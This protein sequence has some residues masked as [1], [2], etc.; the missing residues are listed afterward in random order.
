MTTTIGRTDTEARKAA[1]TGKAYKLWY[2]EGLH[3]FVTPTGTKSWRAKYRLNGK[4]GT[5]VLGQFPTMTTDEAR[6]GCR[7]VLKLVSRGINP[8]AERKRRRAKLQSAD[9]LTVEA[10]ALSWFKVMRKEWSAGYAPQVEARL[11]NHVF[12]KLGAMPIAGVTGKQVQD[13]LHDIADG[14]KERKALPAQAVH[15]RHHL[16]GLFDYSTA[17]EWT[18]EN[19]VRRVGAYLP[20]R[21]KRDEDDA[22]TEGEESKGEE[23]QAHVESIEEAREVLATFEAGAADPML[24]LAHRF[25]ALTATRKL[26]TVEAEWSEISEDGTTWT[27]PARRMKGRRGAK[28]IHVVPLSPAAQDVLRTARVVARSWR[29]TSDY[30]F[31]SSSGKPFNRST[32]N[33][34]LGRALKPTGLE[35]VPHGWRSTFSTILNE[36]DPHDYRIIEVALAHKTFGKTEGHYNGAKFLPQRRTLAERWSSL[37]LDGAPS[38]MTMAGYPSVETRAFQLAA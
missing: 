4:A 32:L 18:E 14:T 24:K 31:P 16:Q 6:S 15:V 21:R 2:G 38:A 29:T 17:N 23:T 25:L 3:L 33:D 30:I 34:A 1:A 26:E 8:R 13:L 12:P 22:E 7:E 35:H 27:I 37:L 5:E 10:V 19:T 11:R 28:R 9:E 36:A 20:K